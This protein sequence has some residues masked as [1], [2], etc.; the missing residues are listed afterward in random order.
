MQKI[1]SVFPKILPIVIFLLP[2]LQIFVAYS[3]QHGLVT[4]SPSVQ[5]FNRAAYRDIYAG[6]IRQGLNGHWTT[7]ISYTTLPSPRIF[8]FNFYFIVL[9]QIDRLFHIDPVDLLHI[10][11]YV[12]G[13]I[14]FLA[15]FFAVKKLLPKSLSLLS[16]FFILVVET[17]FYIPDMQTKPF[18]TWMPSFDWQQQLMERHFGLPHHTFGKAIGALFATLFILSCEKIQKTRLFFIALLSL[19]GGFLLPPY[20]FVFFIAVAAPL[21]LFSLF[22]K[23]LVPYIV[24][25]ACGAIPFLLISL[26][27]KSQFSVIPALANY[28]NIEKGWWDSTDTLIRYASS[29]LLYYP[30][31]ALG[32]FALLAHWSKISWSTKRIALLCISWLVVPIFLVLLSNKPWFPFANARMTDGY[33]Y[34]PAGILAAIGLWGIVELFKPRIRVFITGIF[35]AIIFGVSAVASYNLIHLYFSI[36]SMAWTNFYPYNNTWK[37]VDF[38]KTVPKDSGV[39]TLQYDGEMIPA[40][41]DVR[42]YAATS[43]LTWPHYEERMWLAQQFFT[44]K[45]KSEDAKKFLLDNN[46]TYVF[47]GQDE[48]R[49]TE[50]PSLYPEILTPAYRNDLVTVF[51]IK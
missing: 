50:T 11:Q 28:T 34:F 25:A 16:Y 31:I 18:G 42:I 13:P 7:A 46:I 5:A 14:L 40:Y 24:T 37:A 36:H 22:R 45:W 23:K 3:Y 19:I 48:Q 47:H 30:F 43:G 2:F 29:L 12:M 1:R 10:A 17:G 35:L 21:G 9:G 8:G 20:F 41:A 27:L 38:L 15:T 26:F 6:V 49:F 33:Q 39:L 32:L 51:K 4:A 44:G